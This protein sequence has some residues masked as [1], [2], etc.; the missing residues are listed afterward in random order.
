LLSRLDTTREIDYFRNGGL[1]HHV[2]RH[3]L[4]PEVRS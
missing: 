3:R 2:V 4:T 1:L